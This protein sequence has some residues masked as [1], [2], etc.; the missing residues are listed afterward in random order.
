MTQFTISLP[1]LRERSEDVPHLAQRFLQ[2][3]SVELRRPVQGLSV[4]AVALLQ[5]HPWPGNVRELRNVIRQA[6]LQSKDAMVQRS[7]VQKLLGRTGRSPGRAALTPGRSLKET[8][9]RASQEAERDAISEALR[10]TQGNKSQAARA[11]K[12]DYKTLHLKMKSLG[13]RARDF[14]A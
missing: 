12:T 11:L 14:G 1:P 4:E 10:A 2:E 5:A 13:L 8:A 9:T 6:V 3:V 7:V